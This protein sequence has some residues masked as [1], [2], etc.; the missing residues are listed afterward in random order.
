MLRDAARESALK[1]KD[2]KKLY[3]ELAAIN[4]KVKVLRNAHEEIILRDKQKKVQEQLDRTLEYIGKGGEEK[5]SEFKSWQAQ[6]DVDQENDEILYYPAEGN[7]DPADYP[8]GIVPPP[9]P[10]RPVTES[11]AEGEH[12]EEDEEDIPFPEDDEDGEEGGG[13]GSDSDQEENG[14]TTTTTTSAAA[15]TTIAATT[16]ATT[17]TSSLLPTPPPAALAPPPLPAGLLPPGFVPPP[18]FARPPALPPGMLQPGLVPPPM[19]PGM[20]R[21]ALMLP[22]SSRAPS[23]NTAPPPTFRPPPP[24]DRTEN[25]GDAAPLDAATAKAS[26]I[27]AAPQIVDR[28]QQMLRLAPVALKVRREDPLGPRKK[29]SLSLGVESKPAAPAPQ[30]SKDEAYSKFMDEMKDLL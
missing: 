25:S 18:G 14:T 23:H 21:P 16:T 26:T 11:S 20:L 9:P 27:S 22:P 8:G 5:I 2:P 13:S 4:H 7:P 10:P 24:R 19:P 6:F 1:A 29:P 28:K 30:R 3:Q 17:S 12:G 15:A